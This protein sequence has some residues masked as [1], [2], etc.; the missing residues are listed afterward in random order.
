MY[1]K[2]KNPSAEIF[3]DFE[4]LAHFQ[5]ISILKIDNSWEDLLKEG[6]GINHFKH[7]NNN[8][9]SVHWIKTLTK[10]IL[11]LMILL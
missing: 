7:K 5:W 3:L 11:P 4:N 2:E 6:G 8:H 10:C 1:L 9:V